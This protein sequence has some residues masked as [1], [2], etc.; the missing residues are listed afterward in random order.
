MKKFAY[1]AIV[2]LVGFFSPRPSHAGISLDPIVGP[3]PTDTL[4]CGVPVEFRLRWSGDVGG[5]V[6]SSSN[7]FVLHDNGSGAIWSY[8]LGTDVGGLW[9]PGIDWSVYYYLWFVNVFPNPLSGGPSDTIGFGGFTLFTGIPDGFDSIFAVIPVEF[10][11]SQAGKQICLDS[12]WYWPSN[13]WVWSVSGDL[14]SPTWDGPQCFSIACNPGADPD[15]DGVE[16]CFDNCPNS[17]NP[18]QADTDSDGIGDACC[19]TLRGDL[20]QAGGVNVADITFLVDNLYNTGQGSGCPS[21]G[22]V[23]TSGGTDVA[24]LTYLVDYLFSGGP[25]PVPC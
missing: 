3:W 22:D 15:E 19:C 13:Q 9:N 8:P 1:C 12:S 16:T 7:G 18:G 4:E 21:H 6:T 17:Y 24:D 25:P 10:D 14:Y 23:N 5:D 20:N 2:I 11:C